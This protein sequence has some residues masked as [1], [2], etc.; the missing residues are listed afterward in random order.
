VNGNVQV[1]SVAPEPATVGL[2]MT[3]LAGLVPMYRRR[4]RDQS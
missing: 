2:L 4:K 1:T 3:G